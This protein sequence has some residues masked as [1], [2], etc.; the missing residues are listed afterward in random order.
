[1]S[2]MQPTIVFVHGSY[3][4]GSVWTKVLM[5]LAHEGFRTHAAQLPLESFDGDVASLTRLLDHV[6]GPVLLVGHSYAGAVVTAAGN[7]E[8]VKALAYVCAFAP[9]EGEVF[10]S[11]LSMNPTAYPMP[12]ETDSYGYMWLQAD[13]A[14]EALGQD[15]HRGSLNLLIATQKPMQS[16]SFGRSLKNPAWKHKPNAYLITTEDRVIAPASQHVLAKRMNARAQEVTS[17]HM[18]ILS[19]PE[20]VTDFVR[21]SALALSS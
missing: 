14:V 16:A 21:M 3:C 11:L 15:L 12:S 8:K 18:V 17:S 6:D 10:A 9:D 7:H 2:E 5:P 20:A 1:M 19:H 13:W 4:D